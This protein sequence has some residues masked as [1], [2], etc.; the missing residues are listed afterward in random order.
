MIPNPFRTFIGVIC[1]TGVLVSCSQEQERVD[2]AARTAE[3]YYG[4]LLSGDVSSF[5]EGIDGFSQLPEA[6]RSE[7][8]GNAGMFA[9]KQKKLHGGLL[10]VAADRCESDSLVAEVFMTFAYGDGTKEQVLVP[11]VRHHGLWYMR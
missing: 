6:Y 7:L 5:V 4:Y 2:L 1:L 9:E 8:R 10:T 3:L 11:M